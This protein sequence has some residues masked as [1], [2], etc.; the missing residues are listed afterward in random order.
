M[1]TKLVLRAENRCFLLLRV[2]VYIIRDRRSNRFVEKE[3]KEALNTDC[4]P[5]H[6][7]FGG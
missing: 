2:M 6:V 1:P 3:K 5:K 7:K 4:L